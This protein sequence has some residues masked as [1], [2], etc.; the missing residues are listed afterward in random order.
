MEK[1]SALRVIAMLLK[2]AATIC[3]GLGVA[4]AFYVVVNSTDVLG[5]NVT[6]PAAIFFG[7]VGALLGGTVSFLVLWGMSEM[8]TVFIDIEENTR[9]ARL[10][11][12]RR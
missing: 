10:L 9:A 5:R 8:I 4:S 1:Y 6:N 2:A 11:Q 12:E 3:A 7:F